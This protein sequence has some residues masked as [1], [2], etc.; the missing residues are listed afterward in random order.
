MVMVKTTTKKTT[1]K[2]KAKMISKAR[3]VLKGQ[4]LITFRKK[5]GTVRVLLGTTDLAKIPANDHPK[6][7]RAPNG[8]IV[9]YDLKKMAWRSFIPKTVISVTN[10]SKDQVEL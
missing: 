4:A 2:T 3:K 6:G 10:V 7:G 1:T 5:D 8:T 9:A